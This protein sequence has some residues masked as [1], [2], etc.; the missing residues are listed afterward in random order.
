MNSV[1]RAQGVK[2]QVPQV[3]C[4]SVFQWSSVGDPVTWWGKSL[5]FKN[6][7][8]KEINGG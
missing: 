2:N 3:P 6:P 7:D 5:G 1:E 4:E 8:E